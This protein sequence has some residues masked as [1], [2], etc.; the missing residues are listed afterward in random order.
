MV[1]SIAVLSNFI[2]TI[3]LWPEEL[4][5]EGP[6]LNK[7]LK[8]QDSCD[9]LYFGESS[10]ISYHPLEDS[11]TSS[12]SELID[13]NLPHTIVGDVTH[14]AYHMGIYLPLIER[15][16]TGKKVKTLI[17]T[18]NL[19]TFDQACIHSE[20]ES[21]LQKQA[22][23]YKS[24]PP[25]LIHLMAALNLYDNLNPFERDLD[26][27]RS[28]TKDTLNLKGF[29]F[30][31]PTIKSW[32]EAVKFPGPDG[33]EDMEKRTLADHNIKAFAFIL[34]ED[35]PRIRD[36]DEIVRVCKT[37]GIKLVFNLLPENIEYADSLVG[38]LLTGIIRYN[39]DFLINRYQSKGSIVVDN[40]EIVKGVDYIDQNWTTEHYVYRGRK[41]IADRVS[42]ILRH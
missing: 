38:P 42:Q 23:Y 32:C 27:W 20:L 6:E 17:V 14:P 40:L 1:L 21:A 25:V 24:L 30:P 29:D 33:S 28:W 16:E 9:V 26:M 7:L 15:L 12:I 39:R 8:L 3:W 37:K 31:Y 2:F 22:L 41:A 5:K 11:I 19:R 35:N 4:E 13:K 34:N 10:N 36:C 18:M